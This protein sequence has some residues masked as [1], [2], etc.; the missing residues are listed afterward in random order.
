MERREYLVPGV[1]NFE[2]RR[3]GFRVAH[4]TY[5]YNV[6]VLAKRLD[7]TVF[8]TWHVSAHFSVSDNAFF[9][10]MHILDRATD[11]YDVPVYV[12]VVGINN[13]IHGR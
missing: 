11:D 5:H 12:L 4:L 6:G 13:G 3:D 8:K 10:I 2:R 9:G 1:R 7:N